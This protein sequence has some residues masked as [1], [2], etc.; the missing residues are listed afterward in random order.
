MPAVEFGNTGMGCDIFKDIFSAQRYSKQLPSRPLNLRSEQYQLML[1][2]DHIDNFNKKRARKYNT[3]YSIGVDESMS[4]WYGIGG[5]WINPGL[6]QYNAIDRN[7][8]NGCEIQNASDDVSGIMMQLK[9][10]K[11]SS[12]EDPHSLEE[13]DGLLHGT[14]EC[15]IFFSHW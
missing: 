1:V 2:D 3:S 4:I 14:K 8:G 5:H 12:G 10:F 13:H 6:T 7:P 15:S 9:L 11:T